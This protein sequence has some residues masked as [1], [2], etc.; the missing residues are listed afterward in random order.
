MPE[1][2]RTFT[3]L[4]YLDQLSNGESAVHRLDPRAKLLTVMV[5]IAMVVSFDRYEVSALLPY[6]F[7][8]AVM[9]PVA[10]IPARYI[11]RKY[12]FLLPFAVLIGIFNP[13]FDRDTAMFLGPFAVSGG[14]VSFASILI[15]FT[16]TALAAF[17]LVAVTGFNG[18]CL[19][20]ERFKV[21]KVFCVQLMM[22]YRYTSYSRTRPCGWEKPGTCALQ[23]GKAKG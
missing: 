14:L 12:L 2:A 8:P 1:A 21:P 20:L 22:L 23:E 6:F 5:F 15:R 9:I 19:S 11:A 4:N 3:D 10:G 16:L 7:F 17:I 18:I 13:V